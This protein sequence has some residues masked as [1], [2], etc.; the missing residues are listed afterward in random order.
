MDDITS[1]LNR[2]DAEF[3]A[4]KQNERQFQ[5]EQRHRVMESRESPALRRGATGSDIL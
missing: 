4:G 5:T 2:I 1:L 3:V